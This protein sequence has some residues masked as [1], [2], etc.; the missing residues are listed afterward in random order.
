[1]PGP[2]IVPGTYMQL[3]R[4]Q[5]SGRQW[6]WRAAEFGG[7]GAEAP[8]PEIANR[9]PLAPRP[10]VV[11]VIVIVSILCCLLR[12][13]AHFLSSRAPPTKSVRLLGFGARFVAAASLYK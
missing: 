9:L 2:E 13:V 7:G 3:Q 1:M 5:S 12:F 10:A 4:C 11:V 8:R 6:W